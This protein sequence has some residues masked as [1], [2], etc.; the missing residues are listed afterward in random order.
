MIKLAPNLL[1]QLSKGQLREELMEINIG[2][3]ENSWTN[4]AEPI[5]QKNQQNK[6]PDDWY[7]QKNFE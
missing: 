4:T 7:Q 1:Y 2:C 6:I 3:T 5:Q